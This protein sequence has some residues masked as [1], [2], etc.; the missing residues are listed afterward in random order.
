MSTP[1]FKY[2]PPMVIPKRGSTKSAG[3]ATV[4][5]GVRL[6]QLRRERGLKQ[7]EV[8]SACGMKPSTIS[9]IENGYHSPSVETLVKVLRGMG[10]SEFTL[11]ADQ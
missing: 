11:Q 9:G 1:R 8:A 10:I 6:G 7:S 4:E 2:R 5:V 3:E